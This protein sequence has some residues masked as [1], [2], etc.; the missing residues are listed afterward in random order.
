MHTH[1]FSLVPKKFFF[2]FSVI[3]HILYYIRLGLAAIFRVFLTPDKFLTFLCPSA[4]NM[5]LSCTCSTRPYHAESIH[6]LY[7]HIAFFLY[8]QSQAFSC[9]YVHVHVCMYVYCCHRFFFLFL[10]NIFFFSL[11]LKQYSVVQ[12]ECK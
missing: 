6:L 7:A 9:I 2:A 8:I 3:P 11:S 12:V 1:T 5:H 10:G 4:S